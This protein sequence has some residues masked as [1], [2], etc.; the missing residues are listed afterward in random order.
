MKIPKNC[1]LEK[2]A[3][4]DQTR[5]V[6][7]YIL[8]ENK[9]DET[10]AVATDGR[11][12]AVVPV[13]LCDEDQLDGEKFMLPKA[14]TEARKQ[15]KQAKESTIGL[16]GA[17][18][19]PNGECYPVREDLNFPNWRQVVPT[20]AK[21]TKVCFN[22]KYLYELAQAIGAP[23]DCVQLQ[24][25]ID[26]KTGEI[27]TLGPLVIEESTTGGKGILMPMRHP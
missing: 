27:D 13:V 6:L 21:Y 19:M 17:A 3:S 22:A 9:N 26:K 10:H 8:I 12:L 20:G 23:N 2:V 16:N 14:L 11:K 5:E 18:L 25:E 24:I 7:N 1:K 4:K 15:A